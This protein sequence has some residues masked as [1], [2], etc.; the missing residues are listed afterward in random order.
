M[1]DFAEAVLASAGIV[2]TEI[3][4]RAAVGFVDFGN[5]LDA[6][7][8]TLAV[9]LEVFDASGFAGVERFGAALAFTLAT[10]A[11]FDFAATAVFAGLTGTGTFF[12]ATAFFPA[13]CRDLTDLSPTFATG[14]DDCFEAVDFLAATSVDAGAFGATG[15]SAGFALDATLPACDD[16]RDLEVSLGVGFTGVFP[17]GWRLLAFAGEFLIES[18]YLSIL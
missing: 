6:A 13:S 14:L 12:D 7:L 3:F 8:E 18:L 10:T 9:E 5:V 1:S 15:L 2:L 11:L 4:G 16:G 17:A